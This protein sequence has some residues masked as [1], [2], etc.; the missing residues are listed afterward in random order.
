MKKYEVCI[1]YTKS[2]AYEIEAL[3]EE[4]AKGMAIR[5]ASVD[6]SCNALSVTVGYVVE[7]KD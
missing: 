4:E 3:T 6:E 7:A 1:K 2:V 5:K